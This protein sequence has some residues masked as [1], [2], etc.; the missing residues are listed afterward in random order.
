[1]WE[2]EQLSARATGGKGRPIEEEL[3]KKE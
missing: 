1:M 3:K 2:E